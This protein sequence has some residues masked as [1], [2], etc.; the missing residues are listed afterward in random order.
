MGLTS[1]ADPQRAQTPIALLGGTFDPVHYGHLRF[2]DAA[3]RSLRLP[4]LRLVPARDPPHREGPRASAADRVALLRLA[5]TEFPGLVV[6]ECE[7]GREGKSYTVLTLETLRREH[8]DR[9][10]WFLL[11][12]DAFLGLPAW[13]RWREIFGFAH[14]VVTSRP[15]THMV[16]VPPELAAELQAR[17]TLDP[18]VLCSTPSGAIYFLATPPQDIAATAIRAQLAAGAAGRK[19]VAPLL[20]RAVLA[21]IDRHGLYAPAQ[22]AT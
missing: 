21:Y 5:V 15:D 6:D 9:P 1:A 2:A 17:V 8:P 10:L 4:E 3:R 20:P 11:G 12:V 13:H 16:Q 19:A 14:L 7:I 22:D 18:T